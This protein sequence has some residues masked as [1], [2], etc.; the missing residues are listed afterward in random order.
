[1]KTIGYGTETVTYKAAQLWEL[2]PYDVK[3]PPISIA[4][5]ARRKTWNQIKLPLPFM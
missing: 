2:L 5:K 4:F 3:N 1:M